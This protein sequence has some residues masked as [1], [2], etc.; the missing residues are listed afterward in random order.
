MVDWAHGVTVFAPAKINLYLHVT[1]RRD[2]G[3]HSLDSLVVFA[4][5]GDQLAAAP[6]SSLTLEIDGPF[7]GGLP[8]DDRNLVLAAARALAP[9]A[10]AAKHKGARLRLT[11]ALPVASGIGGGSADAAAA[12]VALDRLWGLGLGA[13]RLREIGLGLGA[14]VPMCIDSRPAF[15]GGIGERLEAPPALPG[16]HLAL[17]NPGAS[18][19][20]PAVFKTRGGPF[21]APARFA[22]A[23]ADA[24]Q[25]A[26]LLGA[27]SN[28]L[29][30]AAMALAPAIN[31]VLAGLRAQPGCLLA[32]MSGSGATCF[33]LF[34]EA[35]AAKTAARTL[36][37]TGWW[38][39]PAGLFGGRA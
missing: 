37:H 38:T 17:V 13:A 28:D 18:L 22:K 35:G 20:T 30:K 31:Q 6:A 10:G 19:S 15:A 8:G 9:E 21:S 34:A 23:P 29:E 2:D 11:K 1:G 26:A 33:G 24:A 16:F 36:A 3:Y 4:D 14:D 32:R 7:A 25:L 39:A 5:A 12:L 27:R